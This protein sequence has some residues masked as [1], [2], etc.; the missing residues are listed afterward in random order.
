MNISSSLPANSACSAYTLQVVAAHTHDTIVA[1]SG[2][3][4]G[5]E[6]RALE[7]RVAALERQLRIDHE[8]LPPTVQEL[9]AQVDAFRHKLETTEALSW[10]GK[11]S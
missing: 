3:E 10:L 4:T 8:D 7:E 9:R 1:A 5:P 6:L 2:A 11:H